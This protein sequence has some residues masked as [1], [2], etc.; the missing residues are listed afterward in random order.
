MWLKVFARVLD[1]N[2][3]YFDYKSKLI[4]NG[5][6]KH[7]RIYLRISPTANLLSDRVGEFSQL[8]YAYYIVVIIVTDIN[9][10][11][12][13]RRGREFYVDFREILQPLITFVREYFRISYYS[14]FLI[15]DTSI[16]K[17]LVNT[18]LKVVTRFR[19]IAQIT[20]D[21]D[22]YSVLRS[23][24]VFELI[25]CHYHTEPLK[26]LCTLV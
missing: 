4:I 11:R 16:D 18:T 10:L 5:R 24:V 20:Y 13:M 1:F 3:S 2:T 26:T 8:H 21:C 19:R 17:A 7:R 25:Q 23:L 6:R 15:T 9:R 22:K 12:L 14:Y